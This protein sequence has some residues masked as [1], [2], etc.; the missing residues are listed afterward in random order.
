MLYLIFKYAVTS[1][2][3]VTVS[4]VAK[5]NDKL[6]AFIGSL[7]MITLLTLIWLKAEEADSSKIENHAYYTFWYVIPSLPM[8]YFFPKIHHSIGFWPALG[9]SVVL[10]LFLYGSFALFLRKFGIDLF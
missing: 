9:T 4:E 3:I 8:F 2:L 6:A 5:K 1:L 10:T 7:P